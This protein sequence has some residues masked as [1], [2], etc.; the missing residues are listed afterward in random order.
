MVGLTFRSLVA[1]LI[2]GQS[3]SRIPQ[4]Q[5]SSPRASNVSIRFEGRF[6]FFVDFKALSQP[7]NFNGPPSCAPFKSIEMLLCLSP[8]LFSISTAFLPLA[9]SS[10]P[11][12]SLSSPLL[13][14]FSSRYS[15][16]SSPL[17]HQGSIRLLEQK[18]ARPRY[19][20]WHSAP[21]PRTSPRQAP[22]TLPG[23]TSRPSVKRASPVSERNRTA[24]EAVTLRRITSRQTFSS[25]SSSQAAS[26]YPAY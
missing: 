5:S 25:T 4:E 19:V 22:T 6:L 18:T 15:A 7:Q 3:W 17:E 16:A 8:S 23:R 9:I 24:S 20:N 1:L 12:S 2:D 10:L 26:I 21:R 13:S 11:Q 14:L